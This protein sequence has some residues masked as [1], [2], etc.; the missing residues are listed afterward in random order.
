MYTFDCK[1][2]RSRSCNKSHN[3]ANF[4]NAYTSLTS[5]SRDLRSQANPWNV[6]FWDSYD[7]ASVSLVPLLN[8]QRELA[9]L[10]V[11]ITY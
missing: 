1:A 6:I 3:L 2:L 10:E 5:G 11:P 7:M 8:A 9:T 4:K